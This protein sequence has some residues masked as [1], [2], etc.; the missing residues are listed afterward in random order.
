MTH[1]VLS[2]GRVAVITGAASGIGLAL[3]KHC[4]G[5]RMR[6]C[7]VD[8]DGDA[9]EQARSAVVQLSADDQVMARTVDVSDFDALSALNV[10][11]RDAF[12]ECA[13][14]VN[15]AVTRVGGALLGSHDNWSQALDVNLRGVINGVQA[16]VPEMVAQ[17]TPGAVVNCGSKQGITMP[18]GNSAYN[19]SK[20]G[21]KAVTEMLAHELRNTD[22]CQVN[23]HLL[24]PGWVTTGKREHQ[25]GAWLPEQVVAKLVDGIARNAFYILCPDNEVTTEM[26]HRRI[27]WAAADIVNDRPPLSRWHAGHADDFKRFQSGLLS[28]QE[29]F[30]GL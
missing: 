21:V 16:F 10:E 15:N 30:P 29:L 3:A 17:G 1:P 13:L 14:L 25:P 8:I 7:L 26:D 4:A 5:M 28:L 9:L 20:A 22:G 23:A 27:L 2:P 24:I 19:V 18:P 6:V 11:V 12:G